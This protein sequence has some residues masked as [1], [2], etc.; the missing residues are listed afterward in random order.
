MEDYIRVD[1]SNMAEVREV[2]F[3][4]IATLITPQVQEVT[5]TCFHNPHALA[6]VAIKYDTQYLRTLMVEPL[7]F[8]GGPLGDLDG[9]TSKPK[10]ERLEIE[11]RLGLKFPSFATKEEAEEI[12]YHMAEIWRKQ[13][14]QLVRTY[15]P[16]ELLPKKN[17]NEALH[18]A[19]AGDA[20]PLDIYLRKEVE[21]PVFETI[22]GE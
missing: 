21:I 19:L 15:I 10:E 16:E 22:S 8:D 18:L 2:Y 9:Y 4:L 13:V 14:L 1:H 6:G 7:V 3:G 20:N 17:I 5:Q 12:N 11:R